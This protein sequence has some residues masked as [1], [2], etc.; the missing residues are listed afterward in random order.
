MST[1]LGLEAIGFVLTVLAVLALTLVSLL[2]KLF[3]T[4]DAS[5]EPD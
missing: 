2:E 5:D 4:R 3:G 1:G